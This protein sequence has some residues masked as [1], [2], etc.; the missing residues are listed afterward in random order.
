[1]TLIKRIY[2]IV[3]ALRCWFKE[4]IKTMNLNVGLKQ[5]KTDTCIR[6]FT[7]I[8]YVPKSCEIYQ[9]EPG[10]PFCFFVVL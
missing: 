8:G 10:C 7:E 2:C 6:G 9:K 3:K 5:C 4:Y 1:M